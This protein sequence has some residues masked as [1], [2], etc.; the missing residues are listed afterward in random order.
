MHLQVDMFPATVRLH[1]GRVVKPARLFVTDDGR[2]AVVAE[3]GRDPVTVATAEGV[4]AERGPRGWTVATADGD[5]TASR[6]G[7]CGCGSPLK[8]ATAAIAFDQ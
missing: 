8:R 6:R 2:A 7:G 4:T 1:D 3:N 5:W